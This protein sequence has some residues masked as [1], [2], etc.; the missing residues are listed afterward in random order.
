MVAIA[1]SAQHPSAHAHTPVED[2]VGSAVVIQAQYGFERAERVLVFNAGGTIGMGPNAS[3]ALAP[4]PVSELVEFAR[5][6][7][8]S[9]FGVTFA[10]FRQP[11]DSSRMRPDD[12]VAI[13]DA[14]VELA[15]GHT[16]IVV[17]H[18][19]DTLAFTASALSFMLAG[20]DRPI[21]VTGA[22]RPISEHR[23]DAP[24][25]LTTACMI[26]S[27]RT[28]ELPIVPEV[29][30]WFY[31]VLLRGNRTSKVDADSYTGFAS[32]NVSPLGTAGVALRIDRGMLLPAGTGGLRRVAGV[33]TDV[34]AVRLHPA[35]DAD[36]LEAILARPGLRGA[37]IEAYGSGNGPTEQEFLDVLARAN[38]RGIVTVITTQC[39]AGT[40]REGY[41]AA[42]A[43]LFETG[44]ISGLDLTFEGAITKLMVL[45]DQ[46][47]GPRVRELMSESLAGELTPI[48]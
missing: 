23:S 32:R 6:R 21:V 40:V 10:S 29:S 35:L 19:T 37:V 41:Y 44:A 34:A 28:H 17:L 24:Q 38:E 36:D 39:G 8:D 25:N 16:G 31:D 5:P 26:A 3:G 47:D 22:Q 18:G 1:G 46:H 48:E 43:A 45:L 14:I 33:C 13:A 2:G 12:W 27:P 4:L 7:D 11:L 9:G 30:V 42:G 15:P 20:V